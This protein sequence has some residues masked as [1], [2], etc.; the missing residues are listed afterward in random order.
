MLLYVHYKNTQHQGLLQYSID[1]LFSMWHG[2]AERFLNVAALSDGF[3]YFDFSRQPA[4]H[5]KISSSACL[6]SEFR[7]TVEMLSVQTATLL[8]VLPQLCEL[9]A[10]LC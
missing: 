7:P 4:T 9:H 3:Q 1:A 8:L 10:S 2:C 5:N 6:R